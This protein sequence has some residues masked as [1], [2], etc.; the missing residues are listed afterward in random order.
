[1]INFFN[2]YIIVAFI[3]AISSCIVAY[4]LIR[5]SEQSTYF[6]L[7]AISKRVEDISKRV[8]EVNNRC[9]LQH[10]SIEELFETCKFLTIKYEKLIAEKK[11][12]GAQQIVLHPVVTKVRKHKK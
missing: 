7:E 2:I 1:M 9:N 10:Q 12:T 11:P 4:S 3:S 6:L 5:L 8:N